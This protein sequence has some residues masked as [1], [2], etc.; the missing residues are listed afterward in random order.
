M[1]EN[2]FPLEMGGPLAGMDFEEVLIKCPSHVEFCSQMWIEETT[3]GIFLAYYNFVMDKLSDPVIKN[4]HEER[5][6]EYVKS[7]KTIPSY[8]ERFK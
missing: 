5:C 2:R 7:N 8:L 4:E 1:H 3:T 6:R